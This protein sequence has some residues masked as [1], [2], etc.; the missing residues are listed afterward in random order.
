[1]PLFN[2]DYFAHWSFIICLSFPYF[3]CSPAMVFVLF[4]AIALSIPTMFWAW[5]SW[6]D[7]VMRWSLVCARCQMLNYFGVFMIVRACRQL[8]YI[9]NN[10][11][12]TGCSYCFDVAK[13]MIDHVHIGIDC[14]F[15]WR[16]WLFCRWM[17]LHFGLQGTELGKVLSHG[18]SRIDWPTVGVLLSREAG[19]TLAADIA[20]Y[21]P[22]SSIG[23]VC[24]VMSVIPNRSTDIGSEFERYSSRIRLTEVLELSIKID[25][26]ITGWAEC[27]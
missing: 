23:M 4:F 6:F 27:W 3:W 17:C 9:H 26:Y 15:R 21:K 25:I 22:C 8:R 2:Y 11:W 18:A 20:L 1:M 24:N 10:E 12:Y 14:P 13:N 19:V 16:Q 7:H 5:L